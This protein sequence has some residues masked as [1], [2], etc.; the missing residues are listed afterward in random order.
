ME[1]HNLSHRYTPLLFI[2]QP[3]RS[4]PIII[5]FTP[6]PCLQTT[7]TLHPYHNCTCRSQSLVVPQA[8]I[9]TSTILKSTLKSYT[10]TT[11]NTKI[12]TT[13]LH[14]GCLHHS[15]TQK[16]LSHCSQYY[17]FT[18][19]QCHAAACITVLSHLTVTMLSTP[20][21]YI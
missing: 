1:I 21:P 2:P 15:P 13:A 9:Y 16:S 20:H 14:I 4:T 19:D 5:W 6:H 7:V 12:H 8:Y 17:S 3:Y 10:H 18:Y 11:V